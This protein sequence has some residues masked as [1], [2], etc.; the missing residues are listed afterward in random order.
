METY[1]WIEDR[2][3]KASYIFWKT[4]MREVYPNVIVEGKKNN[5]ELI[6]SVKAIQNQQNRYIIIFDNSFD[7]SQICREQKVLKQYAD[8]KNNIILLDIICFEYLLLEFDKLIDWIYAPNDEFRN[9]RAK[10]I[11]A[12]NML[13]GAIQSG[14]WDYKGIQEVKAYDIN[15]ENHNIERLSAKL[16]YDLTRNT[17]FEVSKGMLGECWV[18][19]CCEWL[20]R[21]E[22]DICGL[23]DSRLSTTDKMKSIYAGTSLITEFPKAGLEAVL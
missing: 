12:R 19:P 18:K 20:K 11:Y 16:L 21:Q 2:K 17:G 22:N 13:I 14:N 1:L 23:D 9:R 15:L 10:A 8:M 4:L 6:K 7:N 5:S 3:G